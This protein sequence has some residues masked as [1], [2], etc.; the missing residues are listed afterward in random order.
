MTGPVDTGSSYR[1]AVSAEMVFV[2]LP[3]ED[4]VRRIADAGFEVEIWDW[5]KKDI[6]A[7]AKTGAT[8]SSM[9][10]YVTGTLADPD[11]A[12]ELLWRETSSSS[13][14]APCPTW[15][16]SGSPTSPAAA[17]RARAKSPIRPWWTRRR[18]NQQ[19]GSDGDR[20][21]TP[22]RRAGHRCRLDAGRVGGAVVLRM[23]R[24][25]GTTSSRSVMAEP[26]SR[27][28]ARAMARLVSCS[29]S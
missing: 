22:A 26:S 23:T 4:R 3:F 25:G 19:L 24:W 13:S 7:L 20:G 8:F 21:S 28:A 10:G 29:V 1:L 14:N 6:A 5:T 27:E 17:N 15:A 11:G 2:D 16:R 9:T 12:A 18:R